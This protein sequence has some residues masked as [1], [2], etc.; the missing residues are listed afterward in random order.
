M[1]N[2]CTEAYPLAP[3]VPPESWQRPSIALPNSG[4]PRARAQSAAADGARARNRPTVRFGLTSVTEL[5]D[6]SRDCAL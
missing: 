1:A 4:F 2:H 5:A 3:R 6:E